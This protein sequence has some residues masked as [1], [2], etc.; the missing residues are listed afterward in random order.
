MISKM[1]FFHLEPPF[2]WDFCGSKQ[3]NGL[4]AFFHSMKNQSTKHDSNDGNS[5]ETKQKKWIIFEL[6]DEWP[7]YCTYVLEWWRSHKCMRLFL[8]ISTLN[9]GLQRLNSKKGKVVQKH[10]FILMMEMTKAMIPF[11]Q[12]QPKIDWIDR[13]IF[14]LR[15][16]CKSLF[17]ISKN[18]GL[19]SGP[20]FNV[21]VAC[22]LSSQSIFQKASP[23]GFFAQTERVRINH[24]KQVGKECVCRSYGLICDP[25]TVP[26]ER[27]IFC[28]SDVLVISL[29]MSWYAY[30][31]HRTVCWAWRLF[32]VVKDG[33]ICLLRGAHAAAASKEQKSID[34][35]ITWQ[36]K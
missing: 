25:A 3:G 28:R 30:D 12:W 15:A 11:Y 9:V 20:P 8:L 10:G 18:W 13:S 14:V 36:K 19:N 23:F 29:R 17:W 35:F 16:D 2:Y 22:L 4:S 7:I 33:D 6:N 34:I 32:F 24:T 1:Q 26:M 31:F 27:V 5:R 21:W